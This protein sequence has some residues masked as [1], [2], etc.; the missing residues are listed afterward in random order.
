MMK[1]N[2]RTWL[3]TIGLLLILLACVLMYLGTMPAEANL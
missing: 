1:K 2:Q 3:L